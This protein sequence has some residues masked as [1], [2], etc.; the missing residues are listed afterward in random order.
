[1]TAAIKLTALDATRRL[2]VEQSLDAKTLRAVGLEINHG[3]SHLTVGDHR[4]LGLILQAGRDPRCG[5]EPVDVKIVD[6]LDGS[7]GKRRWQHERPPHPWERHGGD[8]ELDALFDAEEAAIHAAKK[9]LAA[10][11]ERTDVV[12][13]LRASGSA[14]RL[15]VMIQATKALDAANKEYQEAVERESVARGRVTTRQLLIQDRCQRELV[16]K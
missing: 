4:L 7:Y 8:A 9:A 5:S 3:A 10:I 12:R 13:D 14:T 16:K 1:M 2:F 15:E 6:F 11:W